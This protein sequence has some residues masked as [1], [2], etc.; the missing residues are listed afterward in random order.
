MVGG[1]S[2]N[3]FTYSGTLSNVGT[4]LWWVTRP[5]RDLRDLQDA[6]KCFAR[7]AEGRRWAGNVELMQ[8]FEL[9][10]PVKT[11]N[12]GSYGS[13]GSGGRTWAA[14]LRSWGLWYDEERVTLTDAGR[15][16]ADS[17]DPREVRNQ[18]VHLLMTFQVTSAY[19]AARRHDPSF[20][21]FPF[22]F[23]LRLLLDR[24]IG[25]LDID[26]IALFLL[27]VKNPDEYNAIVARILDWRK[28]APDEES[29]RCSIES[30]VKRHMQ[31]HSDARSSRDPKTYLGSLRDTAH[32]VVKNVTY[33]PELAYRGKKLTVGKDSH[34]AVDS[35]LKKYHGIQFS[36][37]YEYSEA[38]F[39][40]RFGRRY[41]SQKASKKDT[42]P[43]TTARKKITRIS[44][45]LESLKAGGEALPRPELLKKLQEITTYP[46]G[47]IS[48]TLSENPDLDWLPGD[49]D[50][51]KAHYL[52]C[53]GD[54]TMHA[55]FEL[56]TRGLF[57]KMGF[58]V[59]KMRIPSTT[60]EIDGLIMNEETCMSGLLE[61][62]G[63]KAYTFPVGDC[64]K[65]HNQYIKNFWKKKVDGRTYS[66]DFFVY[67][68]G[69]KTSGLGNFD[70]LMRNAGLRGSVIYAHDFFN[71][72]RLFKDGCASQIKIWN[73]LKSGRHVTWNDLA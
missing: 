15:L 3:R 5:T 36:R 20:E 59:R 8:R 32:T 71:V 61:C 29:K 6:L 44:N 45:A 37:L 18:I 34:K 17:S 23:V 38:T 14:W 30:R 39:A 40:R 25:F 64:E 58:A 33:M 12:T 54:G 47:E 4:K 53:A 31:K 42:K 35:L 9:E 22:R 21:I 55:E 67:V 16:L 60:R 2:R 11:S 57:D 48:A 66:L 68:I 41:D 1:T 7:L 26:E 63:G 56:L 24:R 19:H 49:D 28:G 52:E 70:E 65:M 50:V 73:L 43:M 62:K 72:Y 10:N 51:F 13:R 69:R 46:L 27:Q